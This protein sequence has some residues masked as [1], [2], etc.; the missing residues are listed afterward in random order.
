MGRSCVPED[1]ANL[2]GFINID[3]GTVQALAADRVQWR[4]MLRD[5]CDI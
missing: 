3:L 5:V 4:Q 1:A 2:T